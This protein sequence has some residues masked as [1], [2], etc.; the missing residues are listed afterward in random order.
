MCGALSSM[1]ARRPKVA[2]ATILICD[3]CKT[4]QPAVGTFDLCVSHV[5]GLRGRSSP[6]AKPRGPVRDRVNYEALNQ[7]IMELA[8]TRPMFNGTQA[9]KHLRVRKHF[10]QTAIRKLVGAGKLVSTGTG[11]GRKLS[12]A[13]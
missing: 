7:Q 2:K 6:E 5:K 9:A 3:F 11:A 8:N 10:V 1:K 4:Q 13:H 12:K